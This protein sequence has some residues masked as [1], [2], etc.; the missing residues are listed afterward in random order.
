MTIENCVFNVAGKTVKI[1]NEAALTLILRSKNNKVISAKGN[2]LSS[3]LM[4][5]TQISLFTWKEITKYPVLVAVDNGT[6]SRMF[7]FSKELVI[8]AKPLYILKI[9]RFGKTGTVL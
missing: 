1:Y 7:G 5:V 8:K 9:R 3:I 4:T 2:M 6:C